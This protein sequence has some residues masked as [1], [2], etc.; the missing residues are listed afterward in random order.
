[1]NSRLVY[2]SARTRSGYAARHVL[3]AG[4]L[5][6]QPAS[7]PWEDELHRD[8]MVPSDG[9]AAD[10]NRENLCMD[11]DTS[12]APPGSLLLSFVLSK[13]RVLSSFSCPDAEAG[14]K[15]VRGGRGEMVKGED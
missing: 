4:R 6:S 14:T 11:P 15:R 5:A 2:T 3:P 12:A 9:R 8:V 7:L 10:R 1:M 13:A